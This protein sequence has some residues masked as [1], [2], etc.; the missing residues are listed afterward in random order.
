MKKFDDIVNE[1]KSSDYYQDFQNF[2]LQKL[3]THKLDRRK[4][5]KDN[6][7]MA[8]YDLKNANHSIMRGFAGD[9]S[10][11]QAYEEYKKW[12][13]T[14]EVW[15]LRSKTFRQIVYGH[16]N[17]GRNVKIQERITTAVYNKLPQAAKENVYFLTAD[18]I[19]IDNEYYRDMDRAVEAA[20]QDLQTYLNTKTFIY[21]PSILKFKTYGP[22]AGGHKI[23]V[24]HTLNINQTWIKELFSVPKN[25]FWLWFH[26]YVLE[27]DNR[28]VRNR[29]FEL[30]G[31]IARWN[32][33]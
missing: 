14:S 26:R 18:E 1:V 24:K 12:F 32:E 4:E 9:D 6:Q 27:E 13:D 21:Q 3:P 30:E 11:T 22:H 19:I 15:L 5:I 16:L 23:K 10:Y 8:S 31:M 29:E 25:Q 20:L 7:I 2:D 28:D 33:V 17:C